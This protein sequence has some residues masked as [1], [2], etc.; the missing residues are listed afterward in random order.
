MLHLGPKPGLPA[1]KCGEAAHGTRT[2]Q[3][4][5][6]TTTLTLGAPGLGFCGTFVKTITE[7]EVTTLIQCPGVQVMVNLYSSYQRM[8]NLKWLIGSGQR[9]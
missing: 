2:R 6:V 1:A 7:L 9:T 4:Q 8:A 5:T 3:Y